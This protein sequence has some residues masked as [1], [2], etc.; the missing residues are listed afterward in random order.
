[1]LNPHRNA[2]LEQVEPLLLMGVLQVLA[3]VW[4]QEYDC[5]QF[6]LNIFLIGSCKKDSL[7]FQLNTLRQTAVALTTAKSFSGLKRL[8]F[9]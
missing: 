7:L 6:T 5:G 1:M 8:V 4:I 3:V 9:S 2:T